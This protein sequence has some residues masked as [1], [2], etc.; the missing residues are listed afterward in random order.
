[1]IAAASAMAAAI[2]LAASAR[3]GRPDRARQAVAPAPPRTGSPR[4][5]RRQAG[6]KGV[7]VVAPLDRSLS[8]SDVE[9]F[10]KG[11]AEGLA[12]DAPKRFVASMSKA[13]REGRIF[14]DWMRNKRGSTAI[15]P[16]SLRARPGAS[17]A[18]PLAWSGLARTKRADEYSLKEAIAARE[19]WAGFFEASQTI[20]RAAL[21]FVKGRPGV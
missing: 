9:A 13:R 16:W 18:V 4:G 8:T 5:R 17:V 1:M 11:F 10:T 14:I 6:G 3:R 7:H 21:H 20:P 2:S 12:S 19:G 15:F